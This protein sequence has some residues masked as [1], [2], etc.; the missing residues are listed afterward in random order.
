M[1]Q[2]K[3]KFAS[4]RGR[5]FHK[6]LRDGVNR[7][8]ETQA[9]SKAAPAWMWLKVGTMLLMYFVPF[10]LAV[11]LFHD[12]PALYILMFVFMGLGMAGIGMNVAHDANHGSLSPNRYVNRLLGSTL[13]FIGVD[14]AIW[15]QE[16][17]VEHHTF[18]NIDGFDSDI[19]VPSVLR[20]SPHQKQR[21]IHRFQHIYAW[22]FYALIT[23]RWA[24]VGDFA[25]HIKTHK[26]KE[27]G[28]KKAFRLGL[29]KLILSKL[30]Y[31]AYIW[32]LPMLLLS[33]SPAVALTAFI[34][35]QLVAS[36]ILG[37]IFQTAHVMP[38]SAF[39]NPDSSGRIE[40]HWAIHQMETTCNYALKSRV[41]SWFVGGLNYQIEHHL[42]PNISHF[43]YPKIA[44][45]VRETAKKHGVSYRTYGTFFDAAFAHGIFLKQ[46]GR[47][48]MA[49]A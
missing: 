6:D 39:P 24:T 19:A 26:E 23:L 30:V 13:Y 49:Q 28:S 45:I 32:V 11:T 41:F 9:L 4:G 38:E 3:I 36:F 18:T 2:R 33:I 1:N 42:F 43:H 10:I 31:H 20:F 34:T 21:P 15:Q 40:S 35:M 16:H 12:S 17:N 47:A 22:F 25:R 44:K 46:L 48:P 14:K 7:Y 8:F 37:I 27:G 29:L 5:E